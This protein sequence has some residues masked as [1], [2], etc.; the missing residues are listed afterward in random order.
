MES[1]AYIRLIE[2]EKDAL[3]ELKAIGVDADSIR[4]M[5]PKT[6]YAAIKVKDLDVRAANILKQEML[7][8]GAEAAVAKWASG[9][10]RPTTDVLLMGTLKQYA[11]VLKK[12]KLQPY[13]LK[14]LVAPLK[15]ALMSLD[16]HPTIVRCG[17]RELEL[18]GRTR[19]MGILNLTPDSFSKDGIFQDLGRAVNEGLRLAAEGADI[20]DV[21]GESTR[22]GAVPVSL[23][24]ELARV[25]PVISRLARE[26]DLPIS[27]DTSK[28]R[29]AAEAIEAGATIVNDVTALRG[30]S[31]MAEVC[32]GSDAAVILMHLKGAPRTMQ[33]NPVYDDL[34]GELIGFLKERVAF[35][36]ETGI[37]ASRTMIDPG[38][39]FGKSTGHNLEIIKRM[40]EL[41]SVGRPI[42][43]GP[44]RKSTIGSVLGSA[45]TADRVE[46][47][48]ATI[49][50]AILG[51]AAVVRVH[52][53]REMAA[54][55]KMTDAI[56]QGEAWS[57]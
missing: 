48:G 42:V 16:R 52:D 39:G 49:A 36:E 50:A 2:S 46:G 55:A 57:G 54:V 45:E 38:F 41:R 5:G 28:A 7:A 21:G 29:V 47:T 33:E 14:A 9:F 44:S 25:L 8:K 51:G 56:L 23:D 6:R 19:V 43:I 18:G 3:D 31:G 37:A 35:A 4:I 32:A 24:D 13:G 11:L 15:G 34:I 20:I 30:D 40:T 17:S 1:V 10:T 12:L 53:V 22:P 26:I 27:I